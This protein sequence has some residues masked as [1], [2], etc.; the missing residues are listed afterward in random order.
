VTA[1]TYNDAPY[2][3][4]YTQG[5]KTIYVHSHYRYKNTYISKLA[6]ISYTKPASVRTYQD[7]SYAQWHNRRYTLYTHE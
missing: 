1:A 7:S 4:T 5:N 2:S 6:A 3:H